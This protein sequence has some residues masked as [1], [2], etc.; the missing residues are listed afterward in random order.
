MGRRKDIAGSRFGKL[1]ASEELPMENSMRKWRL[2][3]DCGNSVEVLQKRFLYERGIRSC[4]CDMPSHER[5]GKSESPEHK[6]WQQMKY[7]C[8]NP[9][10]TGYHKY[11]GR[12][13]K[14]CD[15]WQRS[16]T[17]FLRDVG[18]R[19]SMAHTLDRIDNNKGYEPKNVRWTD[20]KTQA[21][22]TSK[23][24]LVEVDGR[25]VTLAEAV[26]E[27]GLNYN[28]VLYRILRGKT[29]QEALR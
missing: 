27:R 15:E 29:P 10:A 17:A 20:Q 6:V 19:P 9:N 28:T 4:G 12:G 5:H 14:V 3:C 8:S 26:E 22:N 21:R 7:R 11:G 25:T 1:I 23:N 24:R 18:Y 16:F 13:I 2:I